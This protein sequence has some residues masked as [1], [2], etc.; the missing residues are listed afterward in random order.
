MIVDFM[1]KT[2]PLYLA[3]AC[4]LCALALAAVT[5]SSCFVSPN[6]ASAVNDLP[7]DVVA[8]SVQTDSAS[9][10][11]VQRIVQK[12]EVARELIFGEVTFTFAAKR[13]QE[14]SG[15]EV[16]E[17]MR[18]IYPGATESEM[19]YR[20]TIAFVQGLAREFPERVATLVS[21]L[22]A[23]VARRFPGRPAYAVAG[24]GGATAFPSGQSGSRAMPRRTE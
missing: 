3:L 5:Y 18:Q 22:E 1:K 14:L 10:G 13:L 8:D 19:W 2:A 16:S 12:Q 6:S 9:R 15:G 21:D 24:N 23:E 7:I 4:A 17:L 11:N 20:Q